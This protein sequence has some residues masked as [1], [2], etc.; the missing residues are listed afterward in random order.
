MKMKRILPMILA[1][2]MVLSMLPMMTVSAYTFFE[3]LTVPVEDVSRHPLPDG[4]DL[5]PGSFT[6]A[7]S[8]DRV[9]T[10]TMVRVEGGTFT[11]GW[12]GDPN[13]VAGVDR[14][15]DT[16]PIEN[17]YVDTFY[18]GQTEVTNSLWNAVMGAG[19][20]NQ[21]AV[22]GQNWYQ[23]HRFLARLYALTGYTFRLATEAEWEYAAKGGPFS[24]QPAYGPGFTGVSAGFNYDGY[25]HGQLRFAGSNL[26]ARVAHTGPLGN[27]AMRRP[28]ILGL[29]DMSGNVEEWVWD[30]WNAER[31]FVEEGDENPT[32][33]GMGWRH[34]QKTR[35]GG[36]N[37]AGIGDHTRYLTARQI[38][39][40][41]GADGGIGFRIVLSE[42]RVS[43]P[44][45]TRS[46]DVIS[47][48]EYPRNIRGPVMDCKAFPIT[49]RDFRWVTS[50]TQT[51]WDDWYGDVISQLDESMRMDGD[52]VMPYNNVWAGDFIGFGR[53]VM[54]IWSTGEMRIHRFDAFDGFYIESI[55]G[56]W[57]SVSNIGIVFVE[58][59]TGRRIDLPYIVMA[60]GLMMVINNMEGLF[61]SPFGSKLQ[62]HFDDVPSGWWVVPDPYAP[63]QPP[64]API[65]TIPIPYGDMP[66]FSRPVIA[67]LV[68]TE[69]LVPSDVTGALIPMYHMNVDWAVLLE[70][71]NGIPLPPVQRNANWLNVANL[72]PAQYA[73]GVFGQD[74][75]L[76]DGP[77]HSWY[78]GAAM[79]GGEHGYRMDFNLNGNAQSRV[80]QAGAFGFSNALT[81]GPWMT[82]N[83][84]I[85]RFLSA[86]GHDRVY[87]QSPNAHFRD[88]DN[89]AN[90]DMILHVLN[91]PALLEQYGTYDSTDGWIL[92]QSD[93][94]YLLENY[95]IGEEWATRYISFADFE[96]GD[97]RS[98]TL[99]PNGQRRSPT[100]FDLGTGHLLR[101]RNNPVEMPTP[102]FNFAGS[103]FRA[104]PPAP[105][106]DPG[107]PGQIPGAGTDIY[108]SRGRWLCDECDRHVFN[109]VCT[110]PDDAAYSALNAAWMIG[111]SLRM[112]TVGLTGQLQT[113]S[114][115]AAL[116]NIVE[117]ALATRDVTG[118][119]VTANNFSNI[120][121]IIT[122]TII[123][124]VTIAGL[125]ETLTVEISYTVATISEITL[126]IPVTGAGAFVPPVNGA[127][128][129]VQPPPPALFAVGLPA[130]QNVTLA[131]VGFWS[132]ADNDGNGIWSAGDTLMR[133]VMLTPNVGFSFA[134]NF[135]V[136][137]ITLGATGVGA[138]AVPPGWSVTNVVILGTGAAEVELTWTLLLPPSLGLDMFN[139]GPN[140]SP[141]RPNASLAAAGT[142]RIWTQLDGVNAL[143]P[144]ANLTVNAE[145]PDGTNAMEFVRVN[146]M[147][148]NPGNVNLI[149]VDK[150]G[151]WQTIILTVSLND[152]EIELILDN[153]L[154]S[155]PV[156]GLDMF[157]NGPNGSPSRPNASLAAA[158]TIRIWTQL[159]GVN[160]TVPYAGLTVTAEFPN[161]ASAM[162]FVRVNNM[163]A[164]PGNVNLIDVSKSAGAWQTIILTVNLNGQE[165]ELTL[166]NS[167]YNPVVFGLQAFNN[168]TN[169]QV[170]SL[171]G[172]IRIWT[173]LDGVNSLV[174][175][176]DLTVTATLLDG[177]NAMEFVRI[178]RIWNN[179]DYV[180]LIDVNKSGNWQYIN[181]TAT[182]S[183]QSVSILL[184]NDMYVP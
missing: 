18:I 33:F 122:A 136:N 29:F 87:A 27:V 97:Q 62:M 166:D 178:N 10:F 1:V 102:G 162:E 98:Y 173:R 131:N 30:A 44:E 168:G 126:N 56:Q 106:A 111:H 43:V 99:T 147:W 81:Y 50:F 90:A 96:R 116:E 31:A 53:S 179:L 6:I 110:D 129:T 19:A 61:A 181:F 28:N 73:A 170:P 2:A 157:N 12:E 72:L 74:P 100:D 52:N 125:P 118:V 115:A 176:S 127:P 24:S 22:T 65:P 26:Q 117:S 42:D 101:Y 155:A 142:I 130:G 183:G 133:S 172:T 135:G 21:N 84:F 68:A 34:N 182:L 63:P 88:P 8:L 35:R 75:R 85:V 184:I 159:D 94:D 105:P 150:N 160:A 103:T 67:N 39:S 60:P 145:F 23:I 152:Q 46:G 55:Y 140:G 95:G 153:T 77:N 5:P 49:H 45:T 174:P 169:A 70:D 120:D 158:G 143:V 82:A 13:A 57:Y 69:N 25:T 36:N 167:L 91:T 92:T 156:F 139:N 14:P 20:N 17:I 51:H 121:G 177:T 124:E 161:G 9:E 175:Y 109:C 151:D 141:S 108:N 146:N 112:G 171:A 164:N 66:D 123:F 138:P 38:R 64:F 40:I 86:S 89:T 165:I 128:F 137:D 80:F 37:D 41:D 79:A 107:I 32:S 83:N 58:E 76:N 16:D 180:N 7:V 113:A 4:I 119:T 132:S 154:F 163:W 144:Y 59:G 15:D 104:T 78:M 47:R 48:M 114:T 134:N 149:D 54:Q 71:V 11:L 148:E 93:I 3:P